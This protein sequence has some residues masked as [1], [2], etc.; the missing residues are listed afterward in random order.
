MLPRERL[1]ARGKISHAPMR[2]R[3]YDKRVKRRSRSLD[4]YTATSKELRCQTHFTTRR[5]G[6]A[7]PL[8]PKPLVND[9]KGMLHRGIVQD[10]GDLR[11]GNRVTLNLARNAQATL[12]RG[13]E[14]GRGMGRGS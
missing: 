11:T 2:V 1:G 7:V 8:I 3:I 14:R 6:L 5:S 9:D 12:S 10:V 13:P 4:S